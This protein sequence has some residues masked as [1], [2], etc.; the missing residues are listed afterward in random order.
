MRIL[1]HGLNYAPEQV[2][3]AVYTTGMAEA[4]ARMGHEVRVVSGQ[5][6]YPQWRVMAGHKAWVFSRCTSAGVEVVRVPHYIP[7]RPTGAR[8]VLHHLSFAVSSFWPLAWHG[9]VWRPDVV[10][11]IAP[12]LIGAPVARLTAALAG[13]RSW[14][15]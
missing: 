15:H 11:A 13:A 12:S 4:L 8:R 5:P 1:V 2:G 14:L 6:Y 3:I 10:I 7:R 9:L